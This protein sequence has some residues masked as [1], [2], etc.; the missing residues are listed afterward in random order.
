MN[1]VE[2]KGYNQPKTKL[3]QQ[4]LDALVSSAETLFA[5]N[6]FYNTSVADICKHAGSAVGTF[7]IYFETKTDVYHFLL[8]KYQKE[9][10]DLLSESISGASSR[11]D[12]ERDGIKCF[13]KY[14]RQNPNVYKVIWGSLSI[15]EK[16]FHNYYESF[17]KSYLHSLKKDGEEVNGADY[18]SL[19]Y[20]L[21]G[22]SNFIGLRAIFEDM[23]DEQIDEMIDSAVMPALAN[24]FIK[25]A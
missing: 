7:Y 1:Q 4:K 24:G 5:E 22:V 11:Y 17:A 23:T 19:A 20:L 15:D 25:K 13:V 9:I 10:K 14:A 2:H 12:K 8:D 18:T 16:L 21:M 6:G 3:G